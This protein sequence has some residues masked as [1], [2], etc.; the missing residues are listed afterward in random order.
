MPSR[1]RSSRDALA[2]P[3]RTSASQR[4]GA[5]A[6]A[7]ACASFDDARTIATLVGHE[8]A[9]H[10]GESSAARRRADHASWCRRTG[11]GE[12]V[13][14]VRH[15][16]TS[17]GGATLRAI[18]RASEGPMRDAVTA[19]AV[20]YARAFGEHGITSTTA[21]VMLLRATVMGAVAD[22]VL[23]RVVAGEQGADA[24]LAAQ[25]ATAARID[26]LSALQLQR[27]ATEEANRPKTI[28]L[29]TLI[30]QRQRGNVE[31]AGNDDRGADGAEERDDE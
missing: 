13:R 29:A 24:R 28:D 6:P 25:L 31:A 19:A 15:A 10:R 26:T 16:L 3:S 2:I 27:L 20:N 23:A 22:A 12:L 17:D 18:A 9:V 11:R 7:T 4:R 8:L 30:A 14:L 5:L 21:A 1:A